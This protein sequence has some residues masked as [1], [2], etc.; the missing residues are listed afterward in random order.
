M[1]S[2]IKRTIFT[3][4]I[5]VVILVISL[6]GFVGCTGESGKSAYEIWLKQGNTGTVQD[7]LDSFVPEITIG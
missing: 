1:N 4:L 7:Y 2:K 5:L 3:A 6:V